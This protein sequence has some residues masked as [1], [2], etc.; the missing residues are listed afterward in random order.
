MAAQRHLKVLGIFIR[1]NLRD[2]KT[3]YMKDLPLVFHYLLQEIKPYPEL[4]A[5]EA[6]VQQRVL[7]AFLQQQPESRAVVEG[8]LI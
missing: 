8:L 7:P 6:F 4:Q 2:G 3:G 5:F 1:L